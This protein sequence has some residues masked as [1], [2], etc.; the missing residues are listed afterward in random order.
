MTKYNVNVCVQGEIYFKGVAA[1]SPEEAKH[2]ALRML[3]E[4][5]LKVVESEVTA[6]LV[7]NDVD[8]NHIDVEKT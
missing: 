7:V 3:D 1:S 2:A 8:E 4:L 6:Y 5:E